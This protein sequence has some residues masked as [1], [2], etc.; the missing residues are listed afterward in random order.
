MKLDPERMGMLADVGLFGGL[1]REALA[2][3]LVDLTVLDVE[4]NALVFK[5][6]D[7]GREMFIVLEGEMEVTKLSRRRGEACV[8]VLG[9]GEWF[10]EMSIVD[11]MP[12]SATVRAISPG[13]VLRVAAADLDALYRID[14]KSYTL[15][16][17]NIAREMS[18]RLRV[19]D[20]ML[21][22]LVAQVTSEVPPGA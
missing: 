3:F 21:A 1:S 19:A 4:T 10:G 5:E 14:V 18:R 20:G 17:M 9:P 2:R 11:V 8:A 16:M 6:G 15:V 22:E 13:R 7:A 12:R